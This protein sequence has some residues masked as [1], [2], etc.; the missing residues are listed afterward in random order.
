M[1]EIVGIFS[2]KGGVGKTTVAVNLGLALQQFGQP[3][4][5][6]DDG[7]NS[8]SIEL[9]L[10]L[11]QYLQ[12][13]KISERKGLRDFIQEHIILHPSGIK[14]IPSFLTSQIF[15]RGA[16]V[17]RKSLRDFDET[18]LIDFSPG[19]H[20]RTKK[21]LEICDSAMIVTTPDV[22]SVTEAMRAKLLVERMGKSVKGVIL[23]RSG[24]SR[25]DLVAKEIEFGFNLP[26][27]GIIPE[28]SEVKR[29]LFRRKPILSLNPYAK[30]SIGFKKI[31]AKLLGREYNPGILAFAKRLRYRLT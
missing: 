1:S 23:N 2:A 6:L 13:Q 31:A 28:D 20:E 4:I 3:I 9:L 24:S 5:L 22:L 14:I 21:V 11:E 17:V 19:L 16:S 18:I 29:S 27:T 25:Y 30:A 15:K 12:P 10:G 8:T 26:I 7:S